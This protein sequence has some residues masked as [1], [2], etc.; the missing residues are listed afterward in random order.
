MKKWNTNTILAFLIVLFVLT[1]VM[2]DENKILPHIEEHIPDPGYDK[3]GDG[4]VS[5][6]TCEEMNGVMLQNVNPM[7]P[8]EILLA[9]QAEVNE[10]NAFNQEH[11]YSWTAAVNPIALMTDEEQKN[12][13]GFRNDLNQLSSHISSKNITA[14]SDLPKSFDWRNYGGDWTNPIRDQ[15]NCASCWA[16][17]V[18][19]VFESYNE[20]KYHNS[21]LNPDYAEQYLVNCAN[22]MQ[23]CNGGGFSSLSYFVDKEGAS[24]G[25]GTVLESDYPYTATDGA[26]KNLSSCT[27][28][29]MDTSVGETWYYVYP[30]PSDIPAID[31]IK[32][33]IYQHGPV[34]SAFYVDKGFYYY[35]SGIY[36]SDTKATYSNHGIIIVGWGEQDGRGYWICKNS[37]GTKWGESGWFKIYADILRIGDSTAFLAYDMPDPKLE[38]VLEPN[39]TGPDYNFTGNYSDGQ[40]IITGAGRYRL[41]DDLTRKT[42]G[43]A[44]TIESPDV[45]LDGYQHTITGSGEGTGIEVQEEGEDCTIQNISR[46]SDFQFGI[47]SFGDHF[48]ISNTQAHNN[49]WS[50]IVSFGNN[51]VITR[52]VASNHNDVGIYSWGHN[53]SIRDNA[54]FYN[55]N[56][57]LS[58][59]N[60]ADISRNMAFYNTKTGIYAGGLYVGPDP[61]EEGHGYYP[62]LSENVA[63]L[64]KKEGINNF[65][66]HAIIENN[67]VI[68]NEAA[69]ITLSAMSSNTSVSGNEMY[70]NPIGINLNDR[71]E[72]LSLYSNFIIASDDAGIF[73]NAGNGNGSGNIFD[74]YLTGQVPVDGSGDIGRYTWN[75][76]SG[77][78]PG[79]NIIGGPY[80]AGNCW[81][82]TNQTGWSDISE[83]DRYKEY[84]YIHQIPAG[85]G[86][87]DTDIPVNKGYSKIPFEIMSGTGVFDNAPLV[88][89][90]YEYLKTHF[91]TSDDMRMNE[92]KM[93]DIFKEISG[94]SLDTSVFKGDVPSHSLSQN[95]GDET[96]EYFVDVSGNPE[97]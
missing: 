93:K 73:V 26:C 55:R 1:P 33:V 25:V 10:L 6:P 66:P 75:H 3:A 7:N 42:S 94:V 64:N 80:I 68:Q 97:E 44:I 31:V 76:P 72:D 51:S 5:G 82:N 16:F 77:P 14:S 57:I 21:H 30:G 50:G 9:T 70:R 91:D 19:G 67:I 62:N 23:G 4:D 20:L 92:E 74:N 71:A 86:F 2:G 11:N 90:D 18:T 15:G 60:Y 32:T 85:I 43:N 38:T 45:F 27:R 37:W 83:F 79:S 49:H 40:I 59:G 36:D 69:G 47:Y 87:V 88:W 22:D 65:F 54:V 48:T 58:Q 84:A 52:N 95:L 53:S 46:I 35:S 63:I 89:N 39:H 41:S 61:G 78:V 56:G 8:E 13:T 24:G 28:Y 17:A 12:L 34:A 29:T 96:I 81:S